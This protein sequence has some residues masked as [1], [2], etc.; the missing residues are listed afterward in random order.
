VFVKFVNVVFEVV[1]EKDRCLLFEQGKIIEVETSQLAI[2]HQ[3]FH[4]NKAALNVFH[5]HNDTGRN[6]VYALDVRDG[7]VIDCIQ[8]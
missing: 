6:Q 5:V 2:V 1:V 4:H 3:F 8:L 7:L